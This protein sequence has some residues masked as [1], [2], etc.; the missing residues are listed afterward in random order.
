MELEKLSE[1]VRSLLATLC[2]TLKLYTCSFSMKGVVT[3]T[4]VLKEVQFQV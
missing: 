3:V 1:E 4:A 2:Q